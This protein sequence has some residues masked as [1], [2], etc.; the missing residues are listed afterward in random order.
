MTVPSIP[1]AHVLITLPLQ[2]KLAFV[3]MY[4]ALVVGFVFVL[5]LLLTVHVVIPNVKSAPLF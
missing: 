4:P 5:V 3:P 1:L 2:A